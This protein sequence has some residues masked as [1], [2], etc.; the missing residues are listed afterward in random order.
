M[1]AEPKRKRRR[2]QFRLRTLMIGVTLFALIPCGYV[3]WQAKIVRDRQAWTAHLAQRGFVPR[4]GDVVIQSGDLK[5][6]NIIRRWMGDKA[7]STIGL[8]EYVSDE[9]KE[10]TLRL[11][12]E[13][14]VV[15]TPSS[16]PQSLTQP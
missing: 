13:T 10:T 7:T 11:F 9:E 14:T 1:E 8:P 12:P 5:Q 3:G 15:Q 16:P 2:F 6:P 4:I